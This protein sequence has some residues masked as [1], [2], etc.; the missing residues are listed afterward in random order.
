MIKKLKKKKKKHQLH[1]IIFIK[2]KVDISRLLKLINQIKDEYWCV[3]HVE[4]AMRFAT[5]AHTWEEHGKEFIHNTIRR[6][7]EIVLY[8]NVI[9]IGI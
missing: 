3:Q 2:K 1:R 4:N 8:F 5:S 7:N 6:D 9:K